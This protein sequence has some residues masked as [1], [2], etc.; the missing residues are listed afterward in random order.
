MILPCWVRYS[1][2]CKVLVAFCVERA[3]DRTHSSE[4]LTVLNRRH[5][6]GGKL[7]LKYPSSTAIV[8]ECIR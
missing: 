5:A 2:N 8:G 7:A 4:G 3:I 6:G 1:R